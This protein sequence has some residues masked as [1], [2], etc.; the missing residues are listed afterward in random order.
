M[1]RL[2]KTDEIVAVWNA[3]SSSSR[4]DE[5]WLT[6]P[7]SDECSC[8]LKAGRRFPGREEAILVGFKSLPSFVGTGFPEGK[9]FVV[10]EAS[11]GKD[12]KG[13]RWLV[14]MRLPAGNLDMFAMMATDIVM[15]LE[16]LRSKAEDRMFSVFLARIRSWQSFMQ[17]GKNGVLGFESEVGLYGELLTL[18]AL[19]NAGMASDMAVESWNGPCGGIQDFMFGNG[20]IEVKTTTSAGTFPA[21]ISSLEQLD[22]SLLSPIYLSAVRICQAGSGT[23]LPDKIEEIRKRF[24]ANSPDVL[25]G[26]ELKLLQAGYIS[27]LADRYTRKYQYVE[28][29]TYLVNEAVPRLIHATV[30]AGVL[31]AKYEIDIE[32][33]NTE[34]LS[35]QQVLH[36]LGAN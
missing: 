7:V 34:I 28:T 22:D 33:I 9:G 15:T 4:T 30:P 1:V 32:T 17:N 11:L 13:Y 27:G 3:L 25:P 21:R 35:L 18:E 36:S 19:A 20:A 14:L 6:L 29:R 8:L 16:S 23:S 2:N 26:F 10:K 5:G 31:R 24:T 12:G